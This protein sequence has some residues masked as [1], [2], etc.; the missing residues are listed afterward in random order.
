MFFNDPGQVDWTVSLLGNIGLKPGVMAFNADFT[1]TGWVVGT[2]I[3]VFT[4]LAG[5]SPW[6]FV[7]VFL[8]PLAWTSFA[9]RG[10]QLVAAFVTP[11]DAVMAESTDDGATWGAFEVLPGAFVQALGISRGRLFAARGDGLWRRIDPVTSV[12]PGAGSGALRFAL[13]GPDPF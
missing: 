1:G 3:G 6:T 7:N 4:S 13:A 2:N 5:Q 8:G 10:G 9:H 12:P 11:N